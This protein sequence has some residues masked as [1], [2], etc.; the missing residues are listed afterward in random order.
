MYLVDNV[1]MMRLNHPAV[2]TLVF[3]TEGQSPSR[4]RSQPDSPFKLNGCVIQPA[5]VTVSGTWVPRS[6][7]RGGP[8]PGRV[9]Q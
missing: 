1:L 9:G 5:A 8:L 3:H 4:K 2:F 6:A 7:R